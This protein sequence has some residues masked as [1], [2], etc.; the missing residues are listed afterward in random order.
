MIGGLRSWSGFAV[1]GSALLLSGAGGL[2]PGGAAG[3]PGCFGQS[4][5]IVGTPGADRISGTNGA[6]VIVT[7]D[8][9]DQVHG[10]G[11]DDR[12]CTGRGGDDLYGE[13]GRDR[14]A[15]GRDGLFPDDD[16]VTADLL[17]G[18]PG[19]DFLDGGPGLRPER[20]G[21]DD[22]VVYRGSPN[23][24]HLDL[25]EGV[26]RIGPDQDTLV[27]VEDVVGSPQ[28][29]T[30]VGDGWEN[31][32]TGLQGDD[33]LRGLDG[34]DRPDGGPGADDAYGGPA[35]DIMFGESGADRLFSGPGDD[36]V[37]GGTEDDRLIG[38]IGDDALY[39]EEGQDFADGGA[40]ERFDRCRAEVITNCER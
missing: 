11:G 26:A 31:D 32:L 33:V 6:D 27:S 7:G 35:Y 16:V 22:Q 40:H 37:Y 34:F 15:A 9:F 12:I 23:P 8:G 3:A 17:V 38:S 10:L 25:S 24:V 36:E 20:R 4:A 28:A 29:D 5:T 2:P 13:D 1:V 39:G 30:L 14:L 21:L 18:G 19:D